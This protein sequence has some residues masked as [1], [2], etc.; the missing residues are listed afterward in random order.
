MRRLFLGMVVLA[1]V[2]GFGVGCQNAARIGCESRTFYLD[3]QRNLFGIDY[4][5][6]AGEFERQPYYGIPA[7]GRQPVCLD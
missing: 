5:H 1:L 3:L 6:G 4:P 7:P 2:A